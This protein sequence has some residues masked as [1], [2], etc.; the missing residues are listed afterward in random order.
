MV[1]EVHICSRFAAVSS[2][3]VRNSG[4]S[5]GG[6]LDFAG[7]DRRLPVSA[8]RCIGDGLDRVSAFHTHFSAGCGMRLAML[9]RSAADPM[10]GWVNEERVA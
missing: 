9:V 10:V 1:D 4:A 5:Q 8:E 2:P 7:C 6:L 3:G